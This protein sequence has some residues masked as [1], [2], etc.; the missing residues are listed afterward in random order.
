M[1]MNEEPGQDIPVRDAYDVVVCGGGLGGTA[2]AIA[3]ARAGARTLLIER[4]S[5]LGGVAT[6]GM[7]CSIFNC[8]YTGIKPRRLGTSGIPVEVADALAEATGYGRK[9]HAHKGHIIYDI[10]R[11]KLVLQDLVEEAGAE[12]LLQTWVSDAIVDD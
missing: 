4:N 9:W 7:C 6:A 12:M 1:E 11:G 2:T 5:F 8:Y 10:E 3:A